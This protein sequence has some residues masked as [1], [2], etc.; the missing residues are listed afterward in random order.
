MRLLIALTVA[1]FST[2][3]VAAPIVGTYA[4]DASDCGNSG[5]LAGVVVSAEGLQQNEL[6]CPTREWH[7]TK[8]GY[9]ALCALESNT[10]HTVTFSLT[11]QADGS[12]IYSEKG[13]T[14]TLHRCR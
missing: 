12:I 14:V 3:A 1:L 8:T 5:V 9:R 10:P 2:A 13:Y 7:R 6:Y 11:H 4:S